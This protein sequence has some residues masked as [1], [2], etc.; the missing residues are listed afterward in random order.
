MKKQDGTKKHVM[1]HIKSARQ[2]LDRAERAFDSESPTRGELDLILARAEVQHAQEK[3]TFL[4]FRNKNTWG[5]ALGGG[6]LCAL[7]F[8]YAGTFVGQHVDLALHAVEPKTQIEIPVKSMLTPATPMVASSENRKSYP[9]VVQEEQ[10][11]VLENA[12]HSMPS[13]QNNVITET[14]ETVRQ[15]ASSAEFR[16]PVSESEMRMLTRTAD[17]ILKSTK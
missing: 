6:V 4:A 9:P 17:R 3:R 11:N 5:L 15:T 10:T 7:L 1:W 2:W 13:G 16:T 8:T 14:S 12:G